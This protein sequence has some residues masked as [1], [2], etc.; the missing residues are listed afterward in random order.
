MST[1][2]K[3]EER[4]DALAAADP[5]YAPA[6]YAFVRD[7]VTHTVKRQ[8][9]GDAA[10]RTHIT[11][12]QLLEGFRE[13]ALER[14]GCLAAEVLEDWGVRRTEDVGDLVFALV[15]SD[16]LGANENDSPADFANGYDFGEVFGA[17]FRPARAGRP[18]EHP[19][20]IA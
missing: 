2:D 8:T 14:F 16:L 9:P 6:A 5:R 19:A 1:H 3:F 15:K 11:G 13:L 12:R 20:P 17:P 4:V 10:R 7:A 18:A